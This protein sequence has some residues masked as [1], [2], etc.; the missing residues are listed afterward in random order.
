MVKGKEP[1][2]R[3]VY[4]TAEGALC[5][6]CQRAQQKC[7][8]AETERARVRGDGNVRV[9]RETAGRAGKTVTAVEGLAFN[10][11]QLESLLKDL[12]R[13]CGAGGSLKEGV[14]EVQGDH[15]E[16][17]LRELAKRGIRAKRS[18]G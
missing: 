15:C 18:G 17:V 6:K 9:R 16:L 12:K 13:I 3:V 4:S 8:C 10:L 14:I 7:V 1:E 2:Y 11:G 5:S